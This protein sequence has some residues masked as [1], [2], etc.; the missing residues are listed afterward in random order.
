MPFTSRDNSK[1]SDRLWGKSGEEILNEL[2]SDLD[3]DRRM[4]FDTPSW[5]QRQNNPTGFRRVSNPT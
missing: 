3:P 1:L 4:F 2:A 5:R